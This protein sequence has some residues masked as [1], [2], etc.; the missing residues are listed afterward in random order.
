M[1]LVAGAP[2]CELNGAVRRAEPLTV[3]HS[4]TYCGGLLRARMQS[5]EAL[6]VQEA[7]QLELEEFTS[8]S[9]NIEHNGYG[10]IA[11]LS[12]TRSSS[13]GGFRGGAS[14]GGAEVFNVGE[15]TGVA[16]YDVLL[17]WIV[18]NR[19]VLASTLSDSLVQLE[20]IVYVLRTGP[21]MPFSFHAR[22]ISMLPIV[23]LRLRLSPQPVPHQNVH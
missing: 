8:L 22:R 6:K 21:V 5:R 23:L 1:A 4:C 18:A 17:F 15:P 14:Y 19:L 10:V 2:M 20:I 16:S 12:S 13:R 3:I 7:I 9:M 11:I